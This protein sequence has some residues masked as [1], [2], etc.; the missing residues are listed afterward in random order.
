MIGASRHVPNPP[1]GVIEVEPLRAHDGLD[2][3]HRPGG[4][5]ETILMVGPSTAHV[6]FEGPVE[7]DADDDDGD[8]FDE[9]DTQLVE[10]DLVGNSSVGT[11]HMH[12]N[13]GIPSVGGMT[14]RTNATPGTLDV[15]PSRRAAWWTASSRSSS[16]SCCPTARCSTTRSRSGLS[17]RISHKP[18]AEL[19]G[20]EGLD[21]IELYDANGN[22]TE[23]VI[24]V[25]HHVP[26]PGPG[27][28]EEDF[29]EQ[30]TALLQLE[31]EPLGPDPVAFVLRGSSEAHVFFEGPVEATR[32]T[33]TATAS[34][35][36]RPSWSRW[37]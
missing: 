29:F 23:Y 7:G 20:Y 33:T 18:P 26:D 19:E 10:L 17:S 6:F 25:S 31:G 2:Q 5:G 12:L 8:G 30:T 1:P 24:G 37:T 28:V 32:W 14:E 35:R 4:T 21:E 11:L 9:V 3:P 34:T 16:R 36:W 27:I 13:P 22:P 15:R